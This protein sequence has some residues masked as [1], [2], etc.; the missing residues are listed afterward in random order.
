MPASEI[1][2]GVVY[3]G[4][5]FGGIGSVLG[6]SRKMALDGWLL[7]LLLGPIGWLLLLLK[8]GSAGQHDD[9]PWRAKVRTRRARQR[10]RKLM[11]AGLGLS[12]L[13]LAAWLI[14]AP[15]RVIY[16][17]P[18]NPSRPGPTPPGVPVATEYV[19]RMVISHG[20]LAV[21]RTFRS[22]GKNCV[23]EYQT[24]LHINRTA[25][26]VSGLLPGKPFPWVHAGGA[27]F[28]T[29]EVPLWIMFLLFAIPSARVF[30][31]HH[32]LPPHCCPSCLYDLTG[33]TSGVCPDAGKAWSKRKLESAKNRG[34]GFPRRE[35][36]EKGFSNQR[37][38]K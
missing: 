35:R 36:F 15:V 38:P 6:K 11:W 29:I 21:Q 22:V 8:R 28:W 30:R 20:E 1:I 5:L 19:T 37:L 34:N 25:D 4:L 23:V 3:W 13:T 31:R 18:D 26:T 27:G 2:K 17:R 7:G 32:H 24:G 12:V 9:R 10:D 33:N 16:V 14:T